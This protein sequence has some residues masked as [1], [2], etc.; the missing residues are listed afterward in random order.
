MEYKCIYVYMFVYIVLV[1]VY[2]YYRML[3]CMISTFGE[4]TPIFEHT[5]R[6]QLF[7]LLVYYFF[8]LRNRWAASDRGREEN[9]NENDIHH[10]FSVLD[11][12]NF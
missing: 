3:Y 6:S 12:F 9:G 4:T 1:H 11:Y 5:Q 7:S 8:S 10:Y 2:W